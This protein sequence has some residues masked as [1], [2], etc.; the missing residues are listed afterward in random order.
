MR[1]LS[2]Q[3]VFL[4]AEQAFKARHCE[5]AISHFV[6][7]SKPRPVITQLNVTYVAEEDR[8]LFRFNTHDGQEFRLWLTRATVRQ[9]LAVGAQAS[10]LAH[11]AQHALPQA[12]A[13]AQFK[14][15]SVEQQAR[16]SEYKPAAQTPLGEAPLLALKVEMK[17]ETKDG[18]SG[19]AIDWTLAGGHQMQLTLDEDLF[20]KFR[21]LLATIQDRAQWGLGPASAVADGDPATADTQPGGT[22]LH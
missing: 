13:I 11:A 22:V 20:A 7:L 1:C 14:Q 3:T 9:L 15:Q 17:V 6:Q 2:H 10:V 21:M 16:F 19:Y 5:A 18:K 8:V 12:Q 4:N